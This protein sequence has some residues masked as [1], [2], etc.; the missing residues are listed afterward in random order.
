M[1]FFLP[2]AVPINSTFA[3]ATDPSTTT[4]LAE[5]DSSNF[6]LNPRTPVE[7]IYGVY[8]YLGGSTSAYWVVESATSTA[9]QPIKTRT[10]IRSATTG[11][12][13]PLPRPAG[14]CPRSE[15]GEVPEGEA[16]A[17]AEQEP[18]QDFS[19]CCHNRGA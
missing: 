14:T 19:R 9:N 16:D 2:G 4:L 12:T 6:Q 10:A 17:P 7:R 1:S 5:L 11:D 18:G 8:A 3:P 13:T 15:T